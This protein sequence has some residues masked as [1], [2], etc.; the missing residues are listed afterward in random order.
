MA[1]LKAHPR[2]ETANRLL[3]RRA[4]RTIK[5]LLHEQRDYLNQLL[6]GFE[7]ALA[8]RDPQSIERH[9]AALVNFLEQID[10]GWDNDDEGEEGKGG[11][12]N[13]CPF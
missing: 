11:G 2:D 13:D 12:N 10:S 4:E 7:T 9:R 3:L 6:D 1:K 5:E 8:M